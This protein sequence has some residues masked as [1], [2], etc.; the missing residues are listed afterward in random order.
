MVQTPRSPP[1]APLV[2]NLR[3]FAH[4]PLRYLDA[5][6]DAYHDPLLRLSGP[7]GDVYVVLSPAF[8]RRILVDDRGRYRKADLRPELTG[9][10]LG[11]G[12]LTAEGDSWARQRRRLDPAFTPRAVREYVASIREHT[13]RLADEWR[14]DADRDLHADMTDVT[15]RVI[16]ETLLGTD[17]D[18]SDVATVAAAMDDLA[19]SFGPSAFRALLPSWFPRRRPS[20]FD[21]AIESLDALAERVIEEHRVLDPPDD[22]VTT[23]LEAV[24][25]GE[26]ERRQVRDEVV[27]LLL[28]GHETTALV[29]T[30][31]W[32]LLSREG[33][34][35]DDSFSREGDD[36]DDGSPNGDEGGGG[37]GDGSVDVGGDR[38]V[39]GRLHDEVDS[40]DGPPGWDDL[41]ALSYVEAVA[42]E[43]MRLYPPVW[44]LFREPRVDAR[45]G[46]YRVPTGT[47]MVLP[48]WA[49]HRDGR[50]FEDPLSFRPGRWLDRTPAETPAFFPFG[51]GPR[52]CIGRTFALVEAE[53]VLATLAREFDITVHDTDPDLDIGIT[54]RPDG[55]VR[56]RVTPRSR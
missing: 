13:A 33:D 45:L 46:D 2:G 26:I 43:S 41:D 44:A 42:N 55:P 39:I 53:L 37:D 50:H 16:A 32:V 27:T 17:L 10:F 9:P 25:S 14:T 30:Y 54:M 18:A 8:V 5:V 11:N 12:L 29:L 56:G 20:G 22:V 28:A 49:I 6:R 31:A 7:G 38:T 4:D 19:D 47:P 23:L 40:L 35:T 34:D 48:Q 52:A 24:D 1:G 15:V 51:A 36:T 3:R 21:R